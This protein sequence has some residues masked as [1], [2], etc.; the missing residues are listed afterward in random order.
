MTN[1]KWNRNIDV[2]IWNGK[3][4]YPDLTIES[5]SYSKIKEDIIKV[6]FHPISFFN[7]VSGFVEADQARGRHL[8]PVL[9]GPVAKD[10]FSET[11]YIETSITSSVR[12][13]GFKAFSL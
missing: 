11:N 2:K 6:T 1:F 4:I 13:N 3:K 5:L 7:N 9:R 10:T 8:G 12:P